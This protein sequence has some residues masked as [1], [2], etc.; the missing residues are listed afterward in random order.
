MEQVC[1]SLA[2]CWKYIIMYFRYSWWRS[3]SWEQ[4]IGKGLLLTTL[5]FVAFFVTRAITGSL[6]A[7]AIVFAIAALAFAMLVADGWLRFII[8]TLG[9]FG[10]A[11][12]VT[13]GLALG[14]LV[15]FGLLF[16]WAGNFLLAEDA[17]KGYF[18][19]KKVVWLSYGMYII[20]LVPI[21]IKVW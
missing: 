20:I 12:S 14:G 17:R 18:I 19:G 3:G 6:E 2:S 10:I 15:C 5:T 1:D 8:L 9:I 21:L 7:A 13:G 4:T 11:Y 16:N